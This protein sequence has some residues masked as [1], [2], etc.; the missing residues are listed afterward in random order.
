MLQNVVAAGYPR[1]YFENMS[2]LRKTRIPQLHHHVCEVL[3]LL[4]IFSSSE[5]TSKIQQPIRKCATRV[6]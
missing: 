1:H 6:C 5:F 2:M 4:V 3:E